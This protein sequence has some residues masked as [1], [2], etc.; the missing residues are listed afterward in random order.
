M[1][2]SRKTL[3][4][5]S[6]ATA[7]VVSTVVTGC[8][9]DDDEEAAPVPVTG[10]VP[11]SAGSSSTLFVSFLKGLAAGDETSVPLT[12]PDAFAPPADETADVIPLG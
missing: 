5:F 10:A 1:K 6:L 12:I 7:L 2:T 4:I 9:T 8:W 11:D 3:R